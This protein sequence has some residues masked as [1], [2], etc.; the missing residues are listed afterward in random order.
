MIYTF[1]GH[2]N[3]PGS[4]KESLKN[5]ISGLIDDGDCEFLVGNNGNFDFWVQKALAEISKTKNVSY[6]IVLSRPDEKALSCDQ[7]HTIF[8]EELDGVPPKFAVSKRNEWMLKRSLTVIAYVKSYFSNS[9]KWI[10][11]AE[12]RGM[13]VL[14]L[15]EEK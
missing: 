11:R 12:K 15:A 7:S 8:P 1:F 6:S 2:R 14:N 10:D 3:A 5:V 4:V 13:A 9:Q